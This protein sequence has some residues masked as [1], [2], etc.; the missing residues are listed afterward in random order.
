[1]PESVG[2][3]IIMIPQQYRAK[4]AVNAIISTH[5]FLYYFL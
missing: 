2:W 4:K 1:M 5:C 3:G